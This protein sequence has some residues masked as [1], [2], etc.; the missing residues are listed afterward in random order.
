M[1][2]RVVYFDGCPCWRTAA[3]RLGHALMLIGQDEVQV[4]LVEV[5]SE[6]DAASS[7]FAGSPTILID[8]DDLF[9][10]PLHGPAL[11]AG[12]LSCRLYPTSTGLAGAPSVDDLVSALTERSR[13]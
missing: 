6:A 7:G 3:E 13:S 8:G 9:P 12:G 10:G 2:A 4:G 11:A 1:E 5:R